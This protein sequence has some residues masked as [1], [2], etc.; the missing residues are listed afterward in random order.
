MRA[1]NA[2]KHDQT[3]KP[4]TDIMHAQ[5][6]ENNHISQQ[7]HYRRDTATSVAFRVFI[8]LLICYFNAMIAR[9]RFPERRRANACSFCSLADSH[10]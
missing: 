9:T 2:L 8:A 4:F 10:P 6:S 3:D 7:I 1:R 5:P